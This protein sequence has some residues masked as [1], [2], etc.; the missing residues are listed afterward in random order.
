MKGVMP[1]VAQGVDERV[2]EDAIRLQG[3]VAIAHSVVEE[4][5]GPVAVS[6]RIPVPS[7]SPLN[8][9]SSRK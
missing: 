1:L 8:G 7:R 9:N 4:G 6:T 5:V 3:D 2:A